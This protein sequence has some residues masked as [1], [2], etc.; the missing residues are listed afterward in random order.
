MAWRY[1]DLAD[2]LVI[3][4]A[5]LQIPAET[6]ARLNRLDLA[7]SALNAPSA[8]FG[9][10]EAYTTFEAKAA[11]LCARLIK[12]HPLPDGNKRA[13]FLSLL[14]FVHRNGREWGRSGDDPA[15]TDA[16]IRGVAAG[17]V[18]EQKLMQWIVA[19]TRTP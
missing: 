18:S 8:G 19:R 10:V 9:D 16:M 14:E 7:D 17:T 6:L 5:I 15:E 13:A 11:V 4:E 1:L 12:N 2:Y 3:A